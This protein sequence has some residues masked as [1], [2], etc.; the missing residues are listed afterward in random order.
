VC[1]RLIVHPSPARDPVARCHVRP[2]VRRLLSH[3]ELAG[4]IRIS[5]E[6]A[7]GA[8]AELLDFGEEV[9]DQMACAIKRSVIFTQRGPVG[10]RRDHG[11]FAGGGQRL[12]GQSGWLANYA[13]RYR[14]KLRVG[15]SI[16]E[17]AANFLVNRRMDKSQQV[18]WSRR[19][20][21]VLLRVRCAVYNGTLGSG[22]G[23][24]FQP[25]ADQNERS[26]KAA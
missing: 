14:A 6:P 5:R 1:P 25:C 22:F 18:R 16:T 24:R 23:R 7:G 17:G 10:P 15:T 8:R 4:A 20:A 9:L 3:R 26:A 21:D 19:G 11:G 2:P 12:R 13:K